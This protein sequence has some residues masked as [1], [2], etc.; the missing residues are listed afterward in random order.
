MSQRKNLRRGDA[1]VALLPHRRKPKEGEACGA[2]QK[3]LRVFWGPAPTTK[4]H[5]SVRWA[6]ARA[7]GHSR[8]TQARAVPTQSRA[9]VERLA[10]ISP[11]RDLPRNPPPG[12]GENACAHPPASVRERSRKIH[13]TLQLTL[14]IHHGRSCCEQLCNDVVAGGDRIAL[15]SALMKEV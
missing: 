12:A 5:G 14:L 9:R 10:A 8:A 1:C 2:P 6:K 4:K 13:G 11:W 7:L 15:I 3:A